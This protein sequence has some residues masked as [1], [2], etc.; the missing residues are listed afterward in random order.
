[1]NFHRNCILAGIFLLSLSGAAAQKPQQEFSFNHFS[2]KDGL[3]HA[4]V[5][6]FCQDKEGFLWIGTYDGLN[7]FDGNEFTVFKMNRRN[8]HS[9]AHNIVHDVCVDKEDNIWCY[10]EGGVSRF[11]KRT[12]KFDNFSLK[13]DSTKNVLVLAEG[14]IICDRQGRIWCSLGWGLFEFIPEKNEFR[15]Y[16]HYA[17]DSTT[18]S[19]SRIPKHSIVEDPTREGLWIGTVRGV[20]YFDTKTKIAYHHKN[21]PQRLPLF[22]DHRTFPVCI[23]KDNRL[24]FGDND[25]SL[26]YFYD[27]SKN[28]LTGT[29]KIL[30]ENRNNFP[31]QTATIYCDSKNNL[32]I[33]TWAYMSYYM[34]GKTGEV[35]EIIHDEANPKSVNSG[36][37]WDVFEDNEGTV[38]FGGVKGISYF[39]P[40]KT[41]YELYR[42]DRRF[43]LLAIHPI[44]CLHEDEKGLL[45]FGAYSAGLFS[46]DFSTDTYTNYSFEKNSGKKEDNR[47]S[48]TSIL[49]M[50]NEWWLGTNQGIMI[51]N[52]E[53]KAFRKFDR[54]PPGEEIEET[55]AFFLTREKEDAVWFYSSQGFICRYDLESKNFKVWRE[56]QADSVKVGMS[57]VFIINSDSSGRIWIGATNKGLLCYDPGRADFRLYPAD[58]A[59]STALPATVI[60][61]VRE[62]SS[63]NVW[64]PVRAQGFSRL[65]PKSGIAKTWNSSDGLVFDPC[66]ELTADHYG[67][68]WITGYNLV[69]VFDPATGRFE[70]FTVEFAESDYN[71]SNRMLTLRN[72]KIVSVLLGAFVVFDPDKQVKK[73][74][75]QK[76]LISRFSI[77]G[78]EIPYTQLNPNLSLSYRENFFTFDYSVF[79]GVDR[80]KI[81]YAYILEGFDKEWVQAGTRQSAAYTNV[82]GGDYVFKVRAR[83]GDN[84][85]TE[86]A[87]TVN[88]HISKIYYQTWWFRF[89]VAAFMFLV[90]RFYVRFRNLQHKKAE[91]QHAIAYFAN[92]EYTNSSPDE[93]LWDLARNCISRLEFVDCVIYLLDEERSVLVQKAALGEKTPDEKTILN[94]IEIPVGKGIVGS[95]AA[96]GK[97]ELVSDTSKDERYIT[98]DASR[99]SEIAVPILFDGKVIG[100][101]DSEHPRRNFFNQEHRRILETIA[102]I[103]ATKIV[104]AQSSQQLA[105]KEKR[106]LEI[107]KRVA[108][109]RL[110]ALRAQMNPHFIFNCLNAIDNYILKND[111][112]NASMYLNKFARLIRSILS[113]S[114]KVYVSL[115]SELELLKNYI[116]LENLR[117]EHK[118]SFRLAVDPGINADEVDIPPMLIQPFVENAIVHGL[119]HKQGEKTLSLEISSQGEYLSCVIEDN[120]IGR[121]E[122]RRIKDS[123]T[124]THESKGMR[125]TEGRLELLQQQVKEKGTVMITDLKHEN[126]N[127]AGTRVEILIPVEI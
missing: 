101:I 34:N 48:V 100:V 24:V 37:W 108:E 119:N 111:V 96:L 17:W 28:E 125:V 84:A 55:Y 87:T 95:V 64:M 114:D 47:N 19:T 40:G 126:G 8:P 107:D 63:G 113:D 85:W 54:N 43:P 16:R 93:I 105:E 29:P 90:I 1:M 49:D 31:T 112:Q 21:N 77:F 33:G 78:K 98:D 32:W 68:F 53:T 38:W 124:Q 61:T 41:V 115:K 51:F 121:E 88:I 45:W 67:K 2:V 52:P 27:I 14:S 26:I 74:P 97:T 46:Y 79:T 25:T 83:S 23:M 117:F 65:D 71:Y 62:D 60:G 3:S 81:Q 118:F 42:P 91:A 122:A 120:G 99:L 11:N 104:N 106:I 103:C 4:I 6:A 69:S 59:D 10:T 30:R 7:R 44:I 35:T 72:G 13:D 75:P 39:N 89:V 15:N 73:I 127:A 76:V 58:L 102:S 66:T 9:L 110:M 94:P 70:N 12:N 92:S 20:N 36:F 22:N 57:Y 80:D 116:E 18:L 86:E 109:V 50:G 82:P 123:K 56:I 5:N